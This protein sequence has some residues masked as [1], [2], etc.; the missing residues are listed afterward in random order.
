[1]FLLFLFFSFFPF[2]FCFVLF[3]CFFFFFF[4]FFSLSFFFLNIIWRP[5]FAFPYPLLCFS[6]LLSSAI[7]YHFF[8]LFFFPSLFFFLIFFFLRPCFAFPYPLVCFSLLLA[9]AIAYLFFFFDVNAFKLHPS[10]QTS[11]NNI[12]YPRPAFIPGLSFCFTHFTV[13]L[14]FFS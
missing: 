5:Y 3:V 8:F 1:M 13:F 7:A 14:F 11:L 4:F 2:F 9:S 10:K 12:V 6:L